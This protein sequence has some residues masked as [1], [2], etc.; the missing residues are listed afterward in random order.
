MFGQQRVCVVF[1]LQGKA[2]IREIQ[3]CAD[4]L[5]VLDNRNNVT[6]FSL[7]TKKRV[8]TYAPPGHVAALLTDP[9]LDY[10]L[11]GL[12]NGESEIRMQIVANEKQETSSLTT[13]TVKP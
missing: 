9:T 6:I 2:S 8:A 11:T 3:F 13:S 1:N 12:Q 10:C 7:D 5:V 4:K